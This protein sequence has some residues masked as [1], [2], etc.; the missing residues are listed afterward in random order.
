MVFH[1]FGEF[2]NP[3]SMVLTEKDYIDYAI[4]LSMTAGEGEEKAT[5]PH[6]IRRCFN[7][8]SPLFLGYRLEDISFIIIFKIFLK[9][10]SK[11]LG[12]GRA[13]QVHLPNIDTIDKKNL[14]KN[15]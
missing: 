6:C 9:L 8:S 12:K 7:G 3:E 1:L 15:I 4:Y 13:F 11:L 2:E 5:L 14:S 10:M